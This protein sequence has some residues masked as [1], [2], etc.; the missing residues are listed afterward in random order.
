M[1]KIKRANGGKK[2]ATRQLA[3]I[4][5]YGGVILQNRAWFAA[6]NVSITSL[7]ATYFPDTHGIRWTA[8]VEVGH[9]P[10]RGTP[11]GLAFKIVNA[12]F[13]GVYQ[14]SCWELRGR[15]L[16]TFE[17]SWFTNNLD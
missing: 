8:T 2:P 4:E 11:M 9:N 10:Q 13:A 7:E 5:D 16:P 12:S 15:T 3:T 17:I 14:P 1:S 6:H